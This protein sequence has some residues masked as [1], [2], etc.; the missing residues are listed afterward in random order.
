MTSLRSLTPGNWITIV[1]VVISI[2][3]NYAVS[4]YQVSE[5]RTGVIENKKSIDI[6]TNKI[7]ELQINSSAN[8]KIIIQM[9]QSQD[10]KI[11]E[12]NKK[13]DKL[14]DRFYNKK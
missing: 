14:E 10:Q 8:G 7:Q 11:E 5:N 2:I 1:L 12:L 6:N 9:L 4:G 13:L 3:A